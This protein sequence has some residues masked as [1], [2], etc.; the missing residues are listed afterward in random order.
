MTT[1]ESFPLHWPLG[2]NRTKYKKK[3][4]FKQTMDGAQRFLRAEL[5]RLGADKVIISTN[6]PIRNDGGMYTAWMG[7]KIEDPGV[8][9]YFKYKEKD[10]VMCCD[11]YETVWE[12]T[13]ALGKGIEALRGMERWGVSDFM[14]RAFMGFT[15]LPEA[16]GMVVT[17]KKAWFELL[18]VSENATE[19][20]ILS[21]YREKAKETHPDKGGTPEQFTV[22]Q[23]AYQEGIKKFANA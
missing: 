4:S 1:A 7:K 23:D 11:Q 13:Y 21:A 20:E 22:I 2:Y 19:A 12:N 6:I 15:A 18:G 14:E 8:A 10:V 3:S 5:T 9:L 16:S 17:Q